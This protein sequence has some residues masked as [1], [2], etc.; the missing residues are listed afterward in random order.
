VSC[1]SC[2]LPQHHPHLEAQH[3]K[4]VIKGRGGARLDGGLLLVGWMEAGGGVSGQQETNGDDGRVDSCATTLVRMCIDTTCC[5]C[6]VSLAGVV[7][8][9]VYTKRGPNDL[10]AWRLAV[11]S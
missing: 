4:V 10:V 6:Y 11:L 3:H 1:L 2:S 7:V 8:S 9:A 5:H